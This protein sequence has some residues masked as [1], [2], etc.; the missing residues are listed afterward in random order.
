VIHLF[1]AHKSKFYILINILYSL[2]HFD[3]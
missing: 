1:K 3:F 2:I